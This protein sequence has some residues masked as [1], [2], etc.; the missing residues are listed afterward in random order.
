MIMDYKK[1]LKNNIKYIY[2]YS[3]FHSL[4]FAYVIERLFWRSRGISVVE[5]VYLEAIYAVF[6]I[7]LEVPSGMW[8]DMWKR[9]SMIV[10]GNCLSALEMLILIFAFNFSTFALVMVVAALSGAVRSGS[11]NALIYDTLVELK[12]EK[13]FEKVLGRVKAFDFASH[14]IAALIGG[15]LAHRIGLLINYKLS[16]ISGCIC[17]ILSLL[18]QEPARSHEITDKG[19]AKRKNL[20]ARNKDF[21]VETIGI[22]KRILRSNAFLRYVVVI[23]VVVGSTMTYMWEFWQNYIEAIGIDIIYFGIVSALCSFAVM[24]AAGKAYTVIGFIKKHKMAKERLYQFSILAIGISFVGMYFVRGLVS[25]GLLIFINLVAG[26]F[27]T[28]SEGDIHHN[29][30]SKHRATIESIYSMF[31]RLSTIGVG[32]AFGMTSDHFDIFSGFGLLGLVL[33]VTFVL[34]PKVKSGKENRFEVME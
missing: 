15:V 24:I 13:D 1:K 3:F 4:V 23:G 28:V 2:L 12:R 7:V 31:M 19:G 6:I 29:I 5:T 9:K 34:I 8:A 14:M 11:S 17:V 20:Y 33:L 16:V 22:T 25:I 18:L 26:L 21:L 30:E 27:E 10:I 32:I